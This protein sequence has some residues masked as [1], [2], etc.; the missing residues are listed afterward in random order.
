LDPVDFPVRDRK[1]RG[2]ES[3]PDPTLDTPRLGELFGKPNNSHGASRVRPRN[4]LGSIGA[5]ST[6]LRRALCG[7]APKSAQA[8]CISAR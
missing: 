2:P 5:T 3:P 8:P 1:T 4:A 6:L 7:V